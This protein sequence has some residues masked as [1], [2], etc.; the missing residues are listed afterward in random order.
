[1]PNKVSYLLKTAN[2]YKRVT[3]RIGKRYAKKTSSTR[4]WMVGLLSGTVGLSYGLGLGSGTLDIAGYYLPDHVFAQ[5]ISTHSDPELTEGVEQAE[6]GHSTPSTSYEIR[7]FANP[8]GQ[9]VEGLIYQVFGKDGELMVKIAECESGMRADAIGDTHIMGTLN[10]EMIGDS[11][12]VFQVRTGDAGV[13]DKRAW[14]R[15]K[16]YGMSVAEFREYLKNPE[17]NVRIAKEIFDTQGAGAWHNCLK[18]V[19]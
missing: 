4:Y 12:G 17:N 7:G 2:G 15:A 8:Q 11:V 13:Y 10:G 19:K 6:A 1:M 5:E 16:Q 9:T 18:K 3:R 14:S